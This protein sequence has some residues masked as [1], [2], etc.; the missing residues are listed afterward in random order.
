MKIHELLK[1]Q[2]STKRL[3]RSI[4][5]KE[6]SIPWQGKLGTT[7]QEEVQLQTSQNYGARVRRGFGKQISS[8]SLAVEYTIRHT[9][10]LIVKLHIVGKEVEAVVNTEASALV[11]GKRLTYKL[12]IWKRARKVKVR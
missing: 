10:L 2:S 1:E 3:Q 8:I 4:K 6:T 5:Y 9:L 7:P 11:V 12:S